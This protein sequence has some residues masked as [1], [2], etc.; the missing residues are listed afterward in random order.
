MRKSLKIFLIVLAELLLVS[1]TIYITY[2]ICYDFYV[3]K[4]F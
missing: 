1:A 3:P 4:W 2:K